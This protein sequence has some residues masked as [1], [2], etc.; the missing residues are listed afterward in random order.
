MFRLAAFTDEISQDLA[1]ACEVCAE[2]GAV[3]VEIRSVNGKGV[4]EFTSRDVRDVKR[5]VE[6]HGLIVCSIASPF[7]K[8]ELD[9]RR[10]VAQH[11]DYLRRC[12]DIAREL[13]SRL[14]RGF[15]FWGHGQRDKPWDEMLRAYEAVPPILEDL[16]IVL[17]IENEYTCHVGTAQDTFRFLNRLGCDSVRAVWD[18]ANHIQDVNNDDVP[19]FPDGYRLIRDRIVHVHVKDAKVAEDAR[20]TV[21]LGQGQVNWAE[22]FQA[23][24]DDG[25]DGFVSLETHVGEEDFPRELEPS[26]GHYR[27]GSNEEAASRVCLAWI[28]DTMGLL[29]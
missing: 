29:R 3:G 7:G 17:G 8:C 24:K 4:Q 12:G 26:Y 11:M 10:E 25:Y 27:S 21:Y 23:L 14:V 15:A 5:I 20:P 13:D 28:R 9:D 2:F 6:S 1:H 22:Q 19:T 16:D 18:P